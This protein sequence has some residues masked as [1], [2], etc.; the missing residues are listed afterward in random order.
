M[1]EDIFYCG[2]AVSDF[3]EA[4]WSC[5]VKQPEKIWRFKTEEEFQRDNRWIK[6]E[7]GASHPSDWN[8]YGNMNYLTGK[9]VQPELFSNGGSFQP[10]IEA[11]K[12]KFRVVAD[13]DADPNRTYWTVDYQDII[14][15]YPVE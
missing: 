2:E 15:D 11:K 10:V 12:G 6:N 3:D 4:A 14:Y 8:D 9:P 5:F 7:S 1:E 13:D